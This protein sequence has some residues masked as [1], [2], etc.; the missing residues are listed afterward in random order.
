[1]D[2]SD[3]ELSFTL[4]L[5]Y[6][7]RSKPRLEIIDFLK[8]H[9][10]IRKTEQP[11]ETFT[12]ISKEPYRAPFEVSELFPKRK[13][14]EQETG[15]IYESHL[16]F[17]TLTRKEIDEI[18]A[19]NNAKRGFPSYSTGSLGRM[20]YFSAIT[21]T[22][23]GYGDIVP[24]TTLSRTVVAIE[25]ILGIIIIGLFVNSTATQISHRKDA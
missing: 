13:S 20:F 3:D 8:L 10:S 4:Y 19:L 16:G 23:L 11:Y 9:V 24:I 22:T 5:I 25:A 2:I 15:L 17:L 14:I 18:I 21:I 1:M 6:S 12:V 7:T